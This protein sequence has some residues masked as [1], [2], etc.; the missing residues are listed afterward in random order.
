MT[1]IAQPTFRPERPPGRPPLRVIQ[2]GRSPARQAGLYRRRRIVVA[3]ALVA[4]ATCTAF[5]GRSALEALRPAVPGAGPAPALRSGASAGGPVVIVRQGDT[6]WSIA[7]SVA[8]G[9]DIRAAVDRLAA[10]HGTG[11]LQVGERLPVGAVTGG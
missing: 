11:P 3:V 2:G 9:G 5:A 6:L 7:R 1:A 4:V 8:P 10:A